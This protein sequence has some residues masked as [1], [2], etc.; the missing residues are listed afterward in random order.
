MTKR[1]HAEGRT[2]ATSPS[3][4][5]PVGRQGR[6]LADA[7]GDGLISRACRWS[8]GIAQLATGDLAGAVAQQREVIAEADGAHDVIW[9]CGGLFM[10]ALTL[11]HHGDPG[12]ARE[13]ANSAIEAAAELGGFHLGMADAAL[14]AATLAA[15]D[16]AAADD[17]IAA[18]WHHLSIQP[19]MAAIW[20]FTW[21]RPRWRAADL[22]AARRWADDTVAA[23]TGLHR[24]LG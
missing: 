9:R 13:A 2:A 18:G 20:I 24:S 3:S 19:K 16:V 15:G 7:M 6:D 23:T 5:S 22:T 11:A 17:A 14:V 4:L 1:R 8:L 12:A 10:Q 21:R